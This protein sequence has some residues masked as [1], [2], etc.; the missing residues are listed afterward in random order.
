MN[1]SED[2]YVHFGRLVKW[3]VHL[4]R[5]ASTTYRITVLITSTESRKNAAGLYMGDIIR[6]KTIF[7][8]KIAKIAQ[9]LPKFNCLK[10]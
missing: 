3:C 10:K 5:H 2:E 4:I 9:K 1:T 8:T 7:K 6:N